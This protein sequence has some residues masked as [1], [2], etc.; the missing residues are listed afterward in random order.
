MKNKNMILKTR[1]IVFICLFQTIFATANHLNE[2][3]EEVYLFV[4]STNHGKSGLNFAWSTDKE[5][6]HEIGP[7][8][9]FLFSDLGSW[10][11][12]KRM[13]SPY[14][15][16]DQEGLWHCIWSLNDDVNVFAH[17][18][19][20]NLYEWKRQ[21]YP[22]TMNDDNFEEPE[23]YY[24]ASI[25][26]YVISWLSQT[27]ENVTKEAY[28]TTTTDFKNYS[29]T[30]KISLSDRKNDRVEITL[31]DKKEEGG[32]PMNEMD[33]YVQDIL[34]LIEWANG[35][36]N[37]KWGKVRAASGH[38]EPFNLK[39][40]GIGNEDLITDVFEERFTMIF[41]AL[42]EK[43]PEITVIGTVGPSYMG[44]DYEEGWDLATKLK[45]PMVDEHYYQSPGWFINNQDYYDTYDRS[46]SKVY[47]GEY[48]A[49]V[50]GR[51]MNIET[52]LS[53]ALYL[54]S[55]ERNADVVSMT[56][57]APLLAKNEHTQWTPDLIYFTN[58]DIKLTVD[59]YVQA[60]YGNNSGE[61]Y[62]PSQ[63]E[64]S[65]NDKKIKQR[66]G[67]S[68]CKRYYNGRFNFEIGKCTSGSCKNIHQFGTF[69]H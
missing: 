19:S 7:N 11:T 31:S 65:S 22:Q 12:E 10:G 36:K 18:A 32:I 43:H 44:T 53:E 56:S 42:K 61:I 15:F 17:A 26:K 69:R 21:S 66:I 68:C 38:P 14:L 57:F 60:L 64:P 40:V 51:H 49:H 45:V 35:D 30:E 6:W 1:L 5:N 50:E 25:A 34:D 58:T 48:A 41:N 55:I 2:N 33:T 63:V 39:Y 52:A 59:Y 23:V 46:K 29:E 4:Y 47:L 3:P 8:H 13:Y 27:G 54:T 24:D 20:K 67:V 62:I 28:R 16:K 9:C 37:T